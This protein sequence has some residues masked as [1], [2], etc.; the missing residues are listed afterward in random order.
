MCLGT[1]ILVYSGEK[2]LELYTNLCIITVHVATAMSS[3]VV[4]GLAGNTIEIMF[5]LSLGLGVYDAD[6]IVLGQRS[7]YAFHGELVGYEAVESVCK[8]GA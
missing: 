2:V 5:K 3:F 8:F 6:T 4:S 7:E 1:M